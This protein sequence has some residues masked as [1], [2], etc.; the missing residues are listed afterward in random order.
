METP[1]WK[2]AQI[3]KFKLDLPEFEIIAFLGRLFTN[4]MQKSIDL[5]NLFV[6]K[7]HD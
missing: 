6:I 5:V 2:Q 1:G 3:T 4:F 7:F